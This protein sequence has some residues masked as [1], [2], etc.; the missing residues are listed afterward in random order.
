M[1]AGFAGIVP[2]T[3]PPEQPLLTGLPRC[4][5]VPKPKLQ[6]LHKNVYGDIRRIDQIG[7]IL[8]N[9][10]LQWFAMVCS[11]Q[12]RGSVVGPITPC[13]SSE[14]ILRETVSKHRP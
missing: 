1:I 7:P 13:T 3:V 8:A 12:R 10:V 14:A 2:S 5:D 4:P 9:C 11:A 6:D